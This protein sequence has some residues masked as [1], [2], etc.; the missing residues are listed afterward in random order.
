MEVDELLSGEL[1]RVPRVP[2]A[3]Q[4]LFKRL[5]DF[6]A[7]GRRSDLSILLGAW[8]QHVGKLKADLLCPDDDR[9]VWGV[10][11]LV[12]AATIRSKLEKELE[13][14]EV[15]NEARSAVDEVDEDFLSFTEGDEEARLARLAEGAPGPR[16]WG[17]R[18]IP[19]GGPARRELD[20][21][22]F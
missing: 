20:T 6:S 14:A 3:D 11:D 9:S 7:S 1:I 12:A 2:Q 16:E 4:W 8:Y 18:R 10:F 21:W 17:W 22:H 15:Q 13:R 19:T 5:G